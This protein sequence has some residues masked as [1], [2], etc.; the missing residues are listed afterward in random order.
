MYRYKGF[1]QQSGNGM[2]KSGSLV[3]LLRLAAKNYRRYGMTG[4]IF[5]PDGT[6]M[7]GEANRLPLPG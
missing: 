4:Q 7:R 2:S 5:R 3:D 1:D 6:D